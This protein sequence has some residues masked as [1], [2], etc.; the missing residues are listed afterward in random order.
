MGI[1]E[2]ALMSGRTKLI[3]SIYDIKNTHIV[4]DNY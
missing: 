1:K 3:C 4:I 2:L